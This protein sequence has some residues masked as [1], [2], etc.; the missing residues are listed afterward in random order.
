MGSAFPGVDVIGE[1]KY[2]LLV[3]IV[4]LHGD[5]D[6]NHLCIAALS[7]LTLFLEVNRP[8]VEDVFVLIEEFNEF[9]DSAL[10]TEVDPLALFALIHEGDSDSAVEERHFTESG[11]KDIEGKVDFFEN[12]RV[13]P[14]CDLRA[15]FARRSDYLPGTFGS[16]PNKAL[17]VKI[18]VPFHVRLQPFR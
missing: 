2:V 5:F 9:T 13:R 1:R 11:C 17:M 18:A 8:T 6:G 3:A 4:V 15:G 7:D 16:P 12:V 14:K 10:E